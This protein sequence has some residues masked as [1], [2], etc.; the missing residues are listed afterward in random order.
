MAGER[1]LRAGPTCGTN[2]FFIAVFIRKDVTTNTAVHP[3]LTTTDIAV[4]PT[5]TTTDYAVHST[6]T[7]TNT[8]VH[9][10]PTSTCVRQNVGS[11]KKTKQVKRHRKRQRKNKLPITVTATK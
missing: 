11:N 3:T 9:A 6:L 10:T 8:A 4:H 1:C 2:G 5:L 7:A